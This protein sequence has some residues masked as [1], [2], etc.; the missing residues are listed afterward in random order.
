MRAM[1]IRVEEVTF[2]RLRA[3]ASDYGV[4]DWSR[5]SKHHLQRD[6]AEAHRRIVE[7]EASRQSH[8]RAVRMR[9]AG[10]GG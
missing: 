5:K 10:H 8:A 7:M 3:I 9:D 4:R 1:L 6:I 2:D